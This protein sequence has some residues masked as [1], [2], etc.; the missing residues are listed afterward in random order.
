VKF[1]N[2]T[3][4]PVR[5]LLPLLQADFIILLRNRRA[6]LVSV[7]LPLVLLFASANQRSQSAQAGPSIMVVLAVTI[8]LLS[9]AI[10]GYA[11]A[12]A[13]DRE[14]GVF[15]RLRVTPAPTWTIMFSRLLVQLLVGLTVAIAV[16]TIGARMDHISVSGS[17]YV[18]TML[19]ATLESALFLAVGQALVGLVKSAA[20]V[21][22]LG[23]LLFVALALSGLWS[24]GGPLGSGFQEFA[25]WTP[26][27]TVV[28]IFQS[29]LHQVAWNLATTLS[30]IAC[31]GYIVLFLLI[32]I[33]WFKWEA[34]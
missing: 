14:R 10:I 1:V 8:G 23:S 12:V 33:K 19:V 5:Y 25:K 29:A 34:R 3:Q 16:L 32:G 30:L 4:K 31:F 21:N 27:G 26:V 6:V 7:M 9:L 20:M 15:Q 22:S 18:N 28:T 24:I 13:R 2:K 17:E 11:S